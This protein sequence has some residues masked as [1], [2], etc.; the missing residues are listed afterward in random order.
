M[1]T[2]LLRYYLPELQGTAWRHLRQAWKDTDVGK[3]K[4]NSLYL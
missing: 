4:T 1:A 2:D 3:E